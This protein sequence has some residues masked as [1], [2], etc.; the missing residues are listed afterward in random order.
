MEQHAWA[1]VWSAGL[2]PGA[3][4]VPDSSIF[5]SNGQMYPLYFLM[6]TLLPAAGSIEEIGNFCEMVGARYTTFE[7]NVQVLVAVVG[8]EGASSDLS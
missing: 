5:P 6:H 4:F 2:I 1:M 8:E 7:E 3:A